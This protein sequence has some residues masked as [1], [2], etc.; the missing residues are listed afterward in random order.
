M[1]VNEPLA[2]QLTV[3]RLR[4]MLD[5]IPDHTVVALLLPPGFQGHPDLSLILN[6]SASYEGGPVL[7]LYPQI[8]PREPA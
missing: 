2:N 7:K 6:V 4:R 8:D 3:E 5:G 1:M